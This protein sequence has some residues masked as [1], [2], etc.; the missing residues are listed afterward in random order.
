MVRAYRAVSF[1]VLI[2]I[3]E[4]PPRIKR[5]M[6]DK[7]TVQKRHSS[8]NETKNSRGLARGM[9][10]RGQRKAKLCNYVVYRG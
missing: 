2:V 7:E 6:G 1:A 10:H 8:R 9:G 3:A 5:H 4:Q